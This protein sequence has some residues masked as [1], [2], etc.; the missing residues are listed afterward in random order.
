MAG[1]PW[2]PYHCPTLFASIDRLHILPKEV[3][4]SPAYHATR[5]PRSWQW[6]GPRT[7][8]ILDLPG[9]AVIEVAVVLMN[10]AGVQVIS[11]FDHWPT[12]TL[13]RTVDVAIDTAPIVNTMSTLGPTVHGIRG[14]LARDAP[15]VW[16]CDSRRLGPPGASPSPGTFDNR[17]YIDDSILPGLN[18]IK[19]AGID[20][21]VY[22]SPSLGDAPS[23]DLRP[24]LIEAIKDGFR[25][26]HVALR[27]ADTW[28]TPRPLE[29]PVETKIPLHSFKRTDLG[30]FGQLIPEPS[31]GGS[32]SS[33]G[34]GG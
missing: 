7:M 4:L 29:T 26:E 10:E 34:G 15:P 17:Y 25:V 16:M 5:P 28:V 30:G 33:G 12:C 23:P 31:E 32:Y 8:V 2:L 19:R 13:T 11:T 20:H 1:S 24:F 6:I 21:V 3:I 18:T 9:S 22:F 14:T 27:E